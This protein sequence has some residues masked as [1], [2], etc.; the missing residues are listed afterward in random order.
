MR[1]AATRLRSGGRFLFCPYTRLRSEI[2]QPL[3]L[4]L[5]QLAERPVAELADPLTRDPHHPADLLQG[6]AP[7]VVQTE[8]EPQHLRIAWR[9]R[10]QRSLDVFGA[11]VGHRRRVGR[12]VL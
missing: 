6:A 2:L 5:A 11:A 12:L 10:R 3:G 9:Q 8:I 1:K 7:A 4:L